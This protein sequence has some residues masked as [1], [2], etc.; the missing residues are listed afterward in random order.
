MTGLRLRYILAIAISTVVF[1]AGCGYTKLSEASQQPKSSAHTKEEVITEYLDITAHSPGFASDLEQVRQHG[2]AILEYVSQRVGASVPTPVKISF[3]PP[4]QRSCPVRATANTISGQITMF[5]PKDIAPKELRA[6]LAHEF[7][8]V[9]D[10]QVLR[11][12]AATV[13]LLEGFATWSAGKYWYE[14]KGARSFAGLARKYLKNG[15]YIAL[16][17]FPHLKIAYPPVGGSSCVKNRDILY[18]EWASFVNFLI[19]QYGMQRLVQL[20]ATPPIKEEGE[21][22]PSPDYQGVYGHTLQQLV[23]TWLDYVKAHANWPPDHL[24]AGRSLVLMFSLE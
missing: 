11:L 21:P 2:D 18:T 1:C 7:G 4:Q 8:H 10:T 22:S 13:G 9:V 16:E 15:T 17:K 19:R 23:K 3:E 6:L 20:M 24:L 14:W 12:R 5:V